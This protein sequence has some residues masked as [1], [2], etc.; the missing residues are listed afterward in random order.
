MSEAMRSMFSRPTF[1]QSVAEDTG[2]WFTP[3]CRLLASC[4]GEEQALTLQEIA[5]F[6]HVPERRTVEQTIES[7]L[8]R[9]PWP[10]VSS[11]AGYFIPTTADEINR[12]LTSLRSRA[13]KIFMRAR[14][15]RIR[16]VAF[17]WHREGRSFV[18]PPRQLDMFE[19]RARAS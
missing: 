8:D 15:V 4:K 9:F 13:V 16:A 3:I 18:N 7:N 14:T 17:G 10:L 19:E 12:Y 2:A 6:L 1:E 11:S 5:D